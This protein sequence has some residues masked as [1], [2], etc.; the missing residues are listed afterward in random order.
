MCDCVNG[1]SCDTGL[2]RLIN[3]VSERS[4]VDSVSPGSPEYVYSAVRTFNCHGGDMLIQKTS[5]PF[6]RGF[7]ILF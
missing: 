3:F 4:C 1:W 7:E 2:F 5:G 6:D